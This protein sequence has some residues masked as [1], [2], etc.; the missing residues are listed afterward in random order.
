MI[1]SSNFVHEYILI[2]IVRKKC[3]FSFIESAVSL[4]GPH[5]VVCGGGHY[6][7]SPEGERAN[8]ICKRY[9]H[10]GSDGDSRWEGITSMTQSRIGA[11]SAVLGKRYT[12]TMVSVCYCTMVFYILKACPIVES[13]LAH[14]WWS[15]QAVPECSKDQ[16]YLFPEHS[17][18]VDDR[19]QVQAGGRHAWGQ[20]RPLHGGHR[21]Q[22]GGGHRYLIFYQCYLF[23]TSP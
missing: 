3:L 15:Q 18:A 1:I 22:Q 2:Y 13:G 21:P 7:R 6:R 8:S 10:S 16:C 4:H 20:V 11:A 5:L 12:A 9:I 14:H 23:L 17:R 19:G